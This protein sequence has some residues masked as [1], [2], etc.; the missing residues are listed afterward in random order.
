MILYRIRRSKPR[1]IGRS[2]AVLR[3]I[4]S[5]CLSIVVCVNSD[6]IKQSTL[7]RP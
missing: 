5:R 1:P 3:E 2:H 4:T 7:T 6:V